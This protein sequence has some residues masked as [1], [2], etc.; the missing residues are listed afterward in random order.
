MKEI[1][2]HDL[3]LDLK[4]HCI[5]LYPDLPLLLILIV[6]VGNCSKG[7]NSIQYFDTLLVKIRGVYD[8]EGYDQLPPCSLRR[9]VFSPSR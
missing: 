4:F 1:V 6:D 3:D 8:L 9:Y 5:L 7:A 2:A